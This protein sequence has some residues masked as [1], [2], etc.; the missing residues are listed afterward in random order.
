[1][2]RYG[3]DNGLDRWWETVSVIKIVVAIVVIAVLAAAIIIWLDL[4][5]TFDHPLKADDTEPTRPTKDV[6][7]GESARR[8]SHGQRRTRGFHDPR[9]LV[10]RLQQR[11]HGHVR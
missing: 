4:H 8:L 2:N 9:R 6:S 3:F 5:V 10:G 11:S 7:S 1:M